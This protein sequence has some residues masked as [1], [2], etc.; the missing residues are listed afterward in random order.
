LPERSAAEIEA[1]AVVPTPID[2]ALVRHLEASRTRVAEPLPQDAPSEYRIGSG[3]ALRITVWNHPDLNLPPNLAVTTITAL[4]G[5]VQPASNVVP[6]RV[7]AHDG[8]LF[9]PLVGKIRAAGRTSLELRDELTRQLARLVKDPQVEV[10]VANFRSKR[11]FMVGELKTPGNLS[12]TDVP[13][14]IADA[15][16]QAGGNTPNADL[17]AVTVTRGDR[18]FTVNLERMYYEGDMSRNLLLQHGDVVTVP[19][20]RE[21]KIFVMGEVMKPTSYILP[22]GRTTLAEAVSDAGGPNPLSSHAGQIFVLRADEQA[23]RP[24]VFQLDAR[25]P[26]ALVLADRFVLQ[27]RDI[28]YV[29]PTQLA[30]AGRLIAQLTPWLQSANVTRQ[31]T[32]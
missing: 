23:D 4:S 30:R 3:D 31:I 21:R 25:S 18:Q 14:R 27:P 9:F 13:L 5:A 12:I 11:V 22:R 19:D 16:G 6:H 1:E 7:V 32:N 26:E 28:V 29:D 2:W 10:E 24:L 8:T 20:R 17:S 15:I